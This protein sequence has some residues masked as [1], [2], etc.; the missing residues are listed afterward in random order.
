MKT[1]VKLPNINEK[2]TYQIKYKSIVLL[3]ISWGGFGR[4]MSKF[5]FIARGRGSQ[6]DLSWAGQWGIWGLWQ[7]VNIRLEARGQP[8]SFQNQGRAAKKSLFLF[9]VGQSQCFLTCQNGIS[10][11]MNSFSLGN[12]ITASSREW[13]MSSDTAP[14]IQKFT[15]TLQFNRSISC[16]SKAGQRQKRGRWLDWPQTK[17]GGGPGR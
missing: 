9:C 5:S 4:E 3:L 10:S 1:K 8:L 2:I 16:K 13:V 17:L 15:S 12:G 11:L 7:N 6:G 14:E